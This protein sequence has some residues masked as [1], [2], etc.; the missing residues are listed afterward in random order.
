MDVAQLFNSLLLRPDVEVVEPC[1]PE[2]I[3]FLG[4]INTGGAPFSLFL[5]DVG[6]GAIAPSSET[7][8]SNHAELQRLNGGGQRLSLRF[9]ISK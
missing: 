7:T 2:V 5:R 3:R 1:L 9:V 6:I 4:T 8:I